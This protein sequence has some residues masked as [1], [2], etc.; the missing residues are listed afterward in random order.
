M[1]KNISRRAFIKGTAVASLS[2]AASTMLTGCTLPDLSS[3]LGPQK[4]A[5]TKDDFSIIITLKD[6]E[7]VPY[8]NQLA[9]T[10]EIKNE[11]VN[12]VEFAKKANSN[13]KYQIIPTF[14]CTDDNSNVSYKISPEL[15]DPI[16]IGLTQTGDLIANITNMSNIQLTLTLYENG[17][18]SSVEPITFALKK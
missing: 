15:K 11:F 13:K 6:C 5:F 2:V 12:E 4:K 17:N 9:P 18:P 3:L 7:F 14:T 8:Y 16:G 1:Y 10:L